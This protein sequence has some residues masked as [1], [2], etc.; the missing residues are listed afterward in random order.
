MK[1]LSGI[2]IFLFST[3]CLFAQDIEVYDRLRDDAAIGEYNTYAMG[4]AFTGAENQEWVK[5]SSL[6]NNMVENSIVYEF[7]TY[8]FDLD[9]ENGE[10]VVNFMVF[11]E[12]YDDKVGYMPGY[13]IDD[14]FG[15]DENLLN[16]LDDG[17]LMISMSDVS[18]GATVWTGFVPNA[19]DKDANLRQQQKDI[20]QA[21]SA[22]M[23]T[24]VAKANFADSPTTRLDLV[25]E[26]VNDV[27]PEDDDSNQ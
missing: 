17:S 3:T 16:K 1:Y 8:G 6:I 12:A 14:E 23:E 5:Y 19:V 11:D 15:L 9:E 26:P 24:F 27:D 7:D 10:L 20:R 2:F 4:N 21:V 13:R 22:A 18:E 25:T